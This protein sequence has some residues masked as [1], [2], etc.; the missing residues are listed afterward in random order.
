MEQPALPPDHRLDE[1]RLG[2]GA[3]DVGAFVDD[4]LRHPGDA[5]AAYEVRKFDG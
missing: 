3:E 1:L 5:E 2:Y 4:R